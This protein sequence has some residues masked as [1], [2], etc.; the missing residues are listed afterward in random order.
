M[1]QKTGILRGVYLFL[2]CIFSKNK[3][4]KYMMYELGCI[5]VLFTTKK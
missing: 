4:K 2:K 1:H 5:F 3:I